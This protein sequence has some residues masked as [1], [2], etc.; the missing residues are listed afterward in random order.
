MVAAAVR[1]CFNALISVSVDAQ[2]RNVHV[3]RPIDK[4]LRSHLADIKQ[5]SGFGDEAH[6]DALHAQQVVQAL[7]HAFHDEARRVPRAA[8][9]ESDHLNNVRVAHGILYLHLFPKSGKRTVESIGVIRWACHLCQSSIKSAMTY[10]PVFYQIDKMHALLDAT[11]RFIVPTDLQQCS[12][13]LAR[14]GRYS[15]FPTKIVVVTALCTRTS[16]FPHCT[17][18]TEL[19]GDN[20]AACH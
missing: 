3:P 11:R 18:T 9:V 2:S 6:V 10:F 5:D 1:V 14:G 4:G 15:R 17:G 20:Y 13:T 8:E 19:P 7:L 16:Y 12:L